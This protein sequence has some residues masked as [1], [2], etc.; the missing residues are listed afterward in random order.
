[1][2]IHS[3]QK[4][5]RDRLNEMIKERQRRGDDR[6]IDIDDVKIEVVED[7]E[8]SPPLKEVNETEDHRSETPKID[9]SERMKR[10]GWQPSRSQ[11][12]EFH[13]QDSITDDEPEDVGGE[14]IPG[15]MGGEEDESD[16]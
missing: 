16:E 2:A 7:A 12:A 1:M 13:P 15:D 10:W 3:H 4:L 5:V 14:S 9:W 11:T 6:R 8:E